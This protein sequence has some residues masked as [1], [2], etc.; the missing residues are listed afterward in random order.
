ME[1]PDSDS[2]DGSESDTSEEDITMLGASDLSEEDRQH[3]LCRLEK[4]LTQTIVLVAKKKK[5]GMYTC[6]SSQRN[7]QKYLVRIKTTPSCTCPDFVQ[8]RG[9]CCNRICVNKTFIGTVIN[10]NYY[11]L[12][13]GF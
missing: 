1:E 7:G 6:K 13:I 8:V 9:F 10:Y 4:A 5:S 12:F 11:I 3:H 2:D